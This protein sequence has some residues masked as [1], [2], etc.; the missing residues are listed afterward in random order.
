M[1]EHRQFFFKCRNIRTWE[2]Y[3]RVLQ[4]AGTL[5]EAETCYVT[6]EGIQPYPE[7]SGELE[8]KPRV[9]LLYTPT[10]PPVISTAEQETLS[11]M[12]E[13]NMEA[14]EQLEADVASHRVETDI[15][16]LIQIHNIRVQYA[17]KLQWNIPGLTA[18][19]A[20]LS[21]FIL[22]YF[23]H[24]YFG[25]LLELCQLRKTPEGE[26]NLPTSNHSTPHQT[27]LPD[28]PTNSSE[29][30]NQQVGFVTY[31]LLPMNPDVNS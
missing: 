5:S 25:K 26:Q 13:I 16:S 10:S 19:G 29:A 11:S 21:L 22:Y 6:S 23:T 18:A 27:A 1:A 14:T 9:P 30:A 20:V 15:D 31:G 12:P 24:P 3:T 4:G 8:Y 28:K 17:R 2:S 7:L